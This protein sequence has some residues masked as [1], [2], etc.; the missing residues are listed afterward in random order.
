MAVYQ[1]VVEGKGPH[2]QH[3]NQNLVS[4]P[5]RWRLLYV[6]ALRQPTIAVSVESFVC[7]IDQLHADPGTV[8][9]EPEASDHFFRLGPTLL[10]YS[11]LSEIYEER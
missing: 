7:Y 3:L 5:G 4:S 1:L 6:Y 2:A 9:L 10:P 11:P 8:H